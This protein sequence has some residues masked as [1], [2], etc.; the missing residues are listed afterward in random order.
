M[1]S[2]N[3]ATIFITA[4]ANKGKVQLPYATQIKTILN[5]VSLLVY[6]KRIDECWGKPQNVRVSDLKGKII[7]ITLPEKDTKS[8]SKLGDSE[9]N[10]KALQNIVNHANQRGVDIAFS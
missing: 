10:E 1:A 5:D 2:E 8:Q 7:R 9:E 6:G 3:L 4:P